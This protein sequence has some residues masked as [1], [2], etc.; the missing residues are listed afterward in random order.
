MGCPMIDWPR[1]RRVVLDLF[2]LGN[3]A[4]LAVDTYLA[5]SVNRFAHPLEWVPFSFSLLATPLFAV[6]IAMVALESCVR[7]G[8]TGPNPT[9][10]S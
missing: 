9:N 1:R 3:I 7:P 2:V 5:H 8:V 4:F 10:P 6:A